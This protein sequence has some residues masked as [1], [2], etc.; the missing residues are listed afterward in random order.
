[1]AEAL[2][3]A[4]GGDRF[5]AYSAGTETASVRPLTLRVLEEAGLPTAG[6]RSKSVS[7]FSGQRF[8]YVVTVCDSARQACPT[9]PG[10][11]Q[12]LHWSCEDPSAAVGTDAERL[13]AFRRVFAAISDRIERFVA[14]DAHSGA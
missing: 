4:K 12:R 14:G 13:E 9:F 3:R 7:E 2:L 8:D 1:M 5:L 11:G 10:D 6:L